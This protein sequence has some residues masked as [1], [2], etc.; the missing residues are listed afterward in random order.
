MRF[1]YEPGEAPPTAVAGCD[2]VMVAMAELNAALEQAYALGLQ[3]QTTVKQAV[4]VY[5]ANTAWSSR[6]WIYIP[7]TS[8]CETRTNEVRNAL[9]G[10]VR[11]IE[12]TTGRPYDYLRPGY[13]APSTG[14][15]GLPVWGYA[16]IGVGGLAALAYV[17]GQVAS[18]ARLWKG[19]KKMSRY[20]RRR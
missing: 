2:S 7:L 16:L 18:V 17:T 12:R 6:I 4:V 11:L 20:R 9:N 19:G 1:G 15:A 5:D 10:L 14:E 8:Q 3:E 13:V